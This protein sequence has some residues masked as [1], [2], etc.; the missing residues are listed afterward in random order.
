MLK[1]KKSTWFENVFK[2]Y[3]RNLIRRRFRSLRV[4]GLEHFENIPVD[5][6]LITYANHSSWWDGL[7]LFEIL[8]RFDLDNYVMMEE[9]HL[10][11]YFLFRRLGAFSI[12]RESPRKFLKSID[13][14]VSILSHNNKANLLIFPQGEIVPNDRRPLAFYRGLS[15]IIARLESVW[16][17]P[18][19]IRLEFLEEFKPDIFVRI[20][21][22]E[23]FAADEEKFASRFQTE[24]LENK[25]I[26][27]LEEIKSDII[28]S[29]LKMYQNLL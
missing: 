2:I 10:R 22:P 28:N 29:N 25:L 18:A 19:A 11:R 13:Y 4:S 7:I 1:A 24:H 6:P 14:A 9:K 17:L 20:G 21:E 27:L 23:M 15:R 16:V 8:T 12:V 26:H 5:I 3:N